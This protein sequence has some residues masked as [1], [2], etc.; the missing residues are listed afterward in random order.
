MGSLALLLIAK[1]EASSTAPKAHIV[2][3][4]ATT[5]FLF[6]KTS[7]VGSHARSVLLDPRAE[8][9][10]SWEASLA[11]VFRNTKR[12]VG[13]HARILILRLLAIP[14]LRLSHT[15]HLQPGAGSADRSSL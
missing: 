13:G 7:I 1:A 5:R 9:Q 15:P 4:S 2:R 11:V 8:P 6:A 14:G 3:N 12:N 10:A